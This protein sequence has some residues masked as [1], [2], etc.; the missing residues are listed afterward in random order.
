[1][2][3]L[4]RSM[5]AITASLV[6]LPTAAAPQE[7]VSIAGRVTSETGVPL[8]SASVF[9]EGMGLGAVTKADGE[10]SIVV[11]SVRVTGEQV[12]ITAR[13][14]GYKPRSATITLLAGAITQDFVIAANP[15]RLDEVVVTG[16]GT[17]ATREKLGSA[18]NVVDS[19]A[20]TN[21]LLGINLKL[22]SWKFA[23]GFV[24]REALAKTEYSGDGFFLEVSKD[25]N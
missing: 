15:L 19:S 2:R 3:P 22:Q 1:M 25:L 11:P 21:E 18:I 14:I 5:L 20:I 8:N 9:L 24:A 12:T 23:T 6:A 10:Y 13:L 4:V 17:S 7:G 16:S